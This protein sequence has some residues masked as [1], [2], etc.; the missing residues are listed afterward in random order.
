M[1]EMGRYAVPCCYCRVVCVVCVHLGIRGA[2]TWDIYYT[3]NQYVLSF[4]R[5]SNFERDR[6]QLAASYLIG[7]CM[8][9]IF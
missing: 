3:V 8:V 5:L 2:E 4:F 9:L 1:K 7:Y 6:K